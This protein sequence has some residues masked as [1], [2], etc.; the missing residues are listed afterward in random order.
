MADNTTE[1][2]S[3]SHD[4][5]AEKLEAL[6]HELRGEE[7]GIDIDVE[8]KTISLDPPETVD[9]EVEVVEHEPMLGDKRESITIELNWQADS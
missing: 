5:V 7:E 1:S 4:E 3:L 2:Q 9:Y 6:V 8:N